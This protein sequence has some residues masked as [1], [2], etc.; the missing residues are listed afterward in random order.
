MVPIVFDVA[1]G[2]I[3]GIA[4]ELIERDGRFVDSKVVV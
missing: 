4:V 1:D 3:E 2:I